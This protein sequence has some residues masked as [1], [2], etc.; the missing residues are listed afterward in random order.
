MGLR[1]DVSQ[2]ARKWH[3]RCQARGKAARGASFS[4]PRPLVPRDLASPTECNRALSTHP[5]SFLAP[6]HALTQLHDYFLSTSPRKIL[7]L[8]PAWLTPALCHS[9][10]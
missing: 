1:T 5:H 8:R 4:A 3:G 6:F 10:L 2:R 7:F 9:N